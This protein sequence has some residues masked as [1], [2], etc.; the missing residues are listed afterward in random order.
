V[1]VRDFKR[2]L[3]HFIMERTKAKVQAARGKE[4][5]AFARLAWFKIEDARKE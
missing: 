3:G 1:S 5:R 2:E 4:K